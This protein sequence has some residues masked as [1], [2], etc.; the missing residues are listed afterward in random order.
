MSVR[1]THKPDKYKKILIPAEQYSAKEDK[2][3]LIPFTHERSIGFMDK[4]G[5][6]VASPVYSMYRGDCYCEDD[7]ITV[8]KPIITWDSQE[9]KYSIDFY[10]GLLNYRG[11]EVLPCKYS[12]VCLPCHCENNIFTVVDSNK[13]YAVLSACGEEIIP[14]GIYDAITGFTN[15]YARVLLHNRWGIINSV[16][17]VVVPIEYNNIWN[18]YDKDWYAVPMIQDNKQY[19]F[20]FEDER[21]T[22]FGEV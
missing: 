1:Q 9:H 12:E 13:H 8:E 22:F 11:E 15:G 4:N 6:V 5:T 19:N 10:E 14:F 21:I 16:G 18:F 17:E 3:L 7:Y 2:R 20:W